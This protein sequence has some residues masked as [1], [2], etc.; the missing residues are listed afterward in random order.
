M[1][2]VDEADTIRRC[3]QGDVPSFT[4]LVA[5]YERE[6]LRLAY[7]LTGDRFLAEDIAQ[8]SFLSA[9]R[10]IARFDTAKPFR[11]WLL[12]IVTNQAR[13]ARRRARRTP[14]VSLNALAASGGD[15]SLANAQMGEQLVAP[16]PD[17]HLA[18]LDEQTALSHALATLTRKQREAVVLR[19]YLDLSDG[20]IA[21]VMQC[22]PDTAR[23]R[24]Y[25]GLRALERSIRR[26]HPWLLE[27]YVGPA[28]AAQPMQSPKPS[29]GAE[30]VYRGVQAI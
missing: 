29:E 21:Q 13:M 10:A 14:A 8:E 19:Y 11:P 15:R 6:A 16:D 12:R 23:H 20:E 4:L 18:A 2:D 3:Q 1:S 7:L 27:E 5:R 17:A 26:Q 22:S 28:T 24:I 30:E 25:D 9:Y